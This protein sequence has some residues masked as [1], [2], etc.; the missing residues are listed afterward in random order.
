MKRKNTN[1]FRHAFVVLI[2]GVVGAQATM[3]QGS[4]GTA[5]NIEPR[6]I[7][8][9]PTA[10]MLPAG[11]FVLEIDFYQGGGVLTG[12]SVGLVDRFSIGLS[13]GGTRLIGADEPVMN[14]IP[15]VSLKV[16]VIEESTL[17]PAIALGFDTQGKDG[18]LRHLDRYVVKSPG[19]YA[20]VSR[21]YPWL[22]FLTLH[23]GINY[24]LEQADNDKD[25]NFYAGVEKSLG[26][27]LSMMM[28]YNLGLNDSDNE[29]TSRGRG[30]LNFGMKWSVGGG[31]TLGLNLKDVVKNAGDVQVG[32]RTV[33]L[34]YLRFF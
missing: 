8:D 7:V 2:A 20:S 14:R 11:S 27:V 15:G 34:E 13:Y 18:F 12:M 10:G 1:Y 16:R 17:L 19:F 22:G 30:F 5:A 4:A 32:N 24:S 3:S 28:E 25:L 29:A 26:P 6:T 31:L 33:E 21:N 23:G 9:M